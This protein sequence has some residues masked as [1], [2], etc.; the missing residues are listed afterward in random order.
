MANQ[1]IPEE[2]NE[3]IQ[4]YLTDGVLTSK[5]REVVLKKAEKMGL[6]RDE[7]DLYLDAQVQKIDQSTDAIMRKQKGKAC[8]ICG[9]PIP[10]LTDKC[11][12]CGQFVTPEA[13]KELQE[14]IENLEE[15]LVDFKSG[16]N[17]DR[18]KATVERF[19][20]KAELYFSN[21]P[22][23]K[24]LLA[25]VKEEMIQAEKVVKSRKRKNLLKNKWTWVTLSFV[26]TIVGVLLAESFKSIERYSI[27]FFFVTA[28]LAIRAIIIDV[29]SLIKKIAK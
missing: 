17:Y 8:P 15:E 11:P 10:L 12:E 9:A 18:S 2:L 29:I 1:L 19:S 24:S 28:I 20:R 13:S 21:N 7:I 16:K 26:L 6:D 4:E 25:I 27:F 5:E 22:K 23:I 3:L 14:I